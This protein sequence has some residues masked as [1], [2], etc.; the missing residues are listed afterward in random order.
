MLLLECDK[1]VQVLRETHV[2]DLQVAVPNMDL[3]SVNY[4]KEDDNQQKGVTVLAE[5]HRW[6]KVRCLD[7]SAFL[8]IPKSLVLLHSI[9]NWAHWSYELHLRCGCG[10][11]IT[12]FFRVM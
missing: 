3:P 10:T 5:V 1:M 2:S 7:S 8:A 12:S 6:P 11:A 4:R 9:C